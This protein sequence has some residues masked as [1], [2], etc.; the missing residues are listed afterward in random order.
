MLL[1]AETAVKGEGDAQ[2]NGWGGGGGGGGEQPMS[3]RDYVYWL[4]NDEICMRNTFKFPHLCE[5]CRGN[6]PK[7]CCTKRAGPD[8]MKGNTH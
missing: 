8:T 2:G 4:Y 3:E 6:H 7:H 5:L 1:E